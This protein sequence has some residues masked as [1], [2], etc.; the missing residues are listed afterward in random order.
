MSQNGSKRIAQLN[1][2]IHI[3]FFHYCEALGTTPLQELQQSNNESWIHN[4]QS[5]GENQTSRKKTGQVPKKALKRFRKH[6]T[7]NLIQL[8]QTAKTNILDPEQNEK[9]AEV[10][11][12]AE[13]DFALELP[14]LVDET[15]I[16][17]R[18]SL[19]KNNNW[20][21]FFYLYCPHRTHLSTTFGLLFYNDK[22]VI[23]ENTRTKFTAMLHQGH[24]S[25]AKMDQ[26]AEAFWLRNAQRY[27]R[28]GRSM[29]KLQS[30]G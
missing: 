5:D 25:A 1:I 19:S 11:K 23:P 13:K 2:E 24:I 14:L 28:K 10:I 8:K 29:P 3:T 18:K 16:L 26:L 9:T 21:T 22:I 27:P 4:Y 15:A 17:Y 20:R 7:V 12:K 30:C 6:E